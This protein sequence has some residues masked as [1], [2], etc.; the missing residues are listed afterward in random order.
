MSA[1]P[2]LPEF[3][4]IVEQK[5]IGN[6]TYYCLNYNPDALANALCNGEDTDMYFPDIVRFKDNDARIYTG[7]C[8]NCPVQQVCLEWGLA[9]ER[10]GIWGGTTPE[11]RSEIRRQIKWGVT[12][13]SLF[14]KSKAS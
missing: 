11:M 5:Q 2:K 7:L 6:L 1:Q 13:P 10:H 3:H 9:H 8:K 14:A 12:D 4:R